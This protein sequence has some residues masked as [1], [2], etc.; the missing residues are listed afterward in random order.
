MGE[1]N[2]EQNIQMLMTSQH[3]TVCVVLTPLNGKNLDDAH[4]PLQAKL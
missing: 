4:R 1:E 2:R 3:D